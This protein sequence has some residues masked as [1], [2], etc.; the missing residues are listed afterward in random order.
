MRAISHCF[1]A[2]AALAFSHT[3]AARAQSVAPT[4]PVA[5]SGTHAWFAVSG[6]GNCRV[7]HHAASMPPGTLREAAVIEGE[8]LAMAAHE[9]QLWIV[10]PMSGHPESHAVYSLTT[11]RN[12]ATG[13]YYDTP[14]GF[15][16]VQPSIVSAT[17]VGS[18]AADSE[19]LYAWLPQDGAPLR[20]LGSRE[21]FT[22]APPQ[23]DCRT[24]FIVASRLSGEP[25]LAVCDIVGD[26]VLDIV[27]EGGPDGLAWSKSQFEGAGEGFAAFVTGAP[28][29]AIVKR[30]TGGGYELAYP[31][32][33]GNR[34]LAA[35]PRQTAPWGV[36]GMTDGFLLAARSGK[37]ELSLSRVDPFSGSVSAPERTTAEVPRTFEWV[38]LP[39]LGAATIALLLVGFVV[40]PPIEAAKPLAAGWVPLP[41][42]RRVVALGID[43]IPGA[44]LA[45][46]VTGEP[47]ERLL[48]MPSWTPE[49]SRC[50]P[51]TF[52]LGTTGAVCLICESLWRAS[53][54]KLLVG[55]RVVRFSDSGDVR[56]G[57]LR[58]MLRAALK[59]VVLFAP[60]LGVLSFVHPQ[61][62]GVSDTITETVVA[63][64]IVVG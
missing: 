5:S 44:V 28:S 59:T 22:V 41:M 57:L 62:R 60:A 13:M 46:V 61:H 25:R 26:G 32:T 42:I 15:L 8:P 64:K 16:D 20:H 33:H 58:A 43:L 2:V 11:H 29:N 50:L 49:L 47:I 56:A 19:G 34:Q 21:W 51:A 31:G 52:M 9:G 23:G 6:E 3:P 27:V 38:H 4:L 45:I 37:N 54:G 17:R 7:L 24:R 10:M 63:R 30:A 12:P 35:I 18:V 1:V 40:R 36:V 14:I 48:A 39:L 53:P 55:A